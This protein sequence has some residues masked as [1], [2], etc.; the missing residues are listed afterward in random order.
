MSIM[1]GPSA[2]LRAARL[3]IANPRL[4]PLA[5]VPAFITCVVSFVGIWLAISYGDDLVAQLWKEPEPGWLHW[6]WWG[7]I[8]LVR[9]SSALLAVFIN[10]WLVILFGVPLSAPLANATDKLLGGDE[11]EVPLLEGIGKT[12]F[13]AICVSA[14]GIS[15]S[16]LLFVLSWL[17]VVGLVMGPLAG[18]VWTPLILCYDLYDG[19][20]SRRQASIKVRVR[21]VLERPIASLSL[22]LTGLGLLS[23]P[24]I[25]LVGLPLAVVGGVIVIRDLEEKGLVD[26]AE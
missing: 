9:I 13:V 16:L 25:N 20:M 14:V 12:L 7:V 26:F 6:I 5:L 19:S 4:I 21:T 11:V 1:T 15:G 17:P 2:V 10:P 3:L 18:F 23:I 8:Q 24:V 22:G